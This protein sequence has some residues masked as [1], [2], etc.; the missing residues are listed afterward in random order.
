M[1]LMTPADLE[2]GR[3]FAAD[4]MLKIADMRPAAAVAGLA[5]ALAGATR[6]AGCGPVAVVRL[7][8]RFY[9]MLVEEA[10]RT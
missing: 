8:Q 1:A 2:K 5:L 4:L 6:M 7:F 3:E 9:T 10:K